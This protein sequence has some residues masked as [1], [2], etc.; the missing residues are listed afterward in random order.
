M[1]K[2]YIY[3]GIIVT[4]MGCNNSTFTE[5]G[6]VGGWHLDNGKIILSLGWSSR[7]SQV[8]G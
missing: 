6:V 3:I 1:K 2:I 4:I 7:P 8:Y 5:Q